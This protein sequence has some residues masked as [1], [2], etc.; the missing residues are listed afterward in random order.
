MP[1]TARLSDSISHGGVI[2]TGSPDHWDENLNVARLTDLA[3]CAKHG[4]VVVIGMS[5]HT[6]VNNLTLARVGDPCTCG[7]VIV[8]G[9][10]HQWLDE[11]E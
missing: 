10:S 2:I 1:K 7:A 6:K 9:S 8:T 3:A 11:E 5:K 4:I